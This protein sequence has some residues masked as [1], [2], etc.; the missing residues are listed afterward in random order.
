MKWPFATRV[1]TVL[2]FVLLASLLIQAGTAVLLDLS[3]DALEG[4]LLAPLYSALDLWTADSQV[5][6]SGFERRSEGLEVRQ[7]FLLRDTVLAGAAEVWRAIPPAAK[8]RL[9]AGETVHVRR[10]RDGLFSVAL[11]RVHGRGEQARAFSLSRALPAY[12]R[13]LALARWN[14]L[15]R[16]LG[17]LLLLGAV[18]LVTREL[19]RPFR[20]LQTVAFDAREELRMKSL[21]PQEEWEAVIGT[22]EATI[23]QLR[24]SQRRLHERYVDSES[25]RQRLDRLN[26]QL[27]DALPSALV[28]AD[29][30]GRIVQFNRSAERLPALPAPEQGMHLAE[31][32]APWPELASRFREASPPEVDPAGE[33]MV[34]VNGEKHAFEFSVY[35]VPGGGHL[36]FLQDCT[37]VRRLEALVSQRARMAALGETAAGLAHE[38]RNAMGAIVGYARLLLRPGRTMVDE[39]APR[40]EEEASEMETML[41][42]FL[43]VARPA[44]LQRVTVDGTELLREAAERFRT[45]F[46]AA[47][48]TLELEAG[49]PLRLELDPMWFKQAIVNLL[50]NALQHVPAGG[51][52]LISCEAG[53]DRWQVKVADDGPGIAPEWRSRVLAPFVSLRP[54][55]TGLGLALVQKVMTAHDGQVEISVSEWGGAQ[56]ILTFASNVR[57][58]APDQAVQNSP[59]APGA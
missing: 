12:G 37:Q 39:V 50:E 20:K 38:L 44:E 13:F 59:S 17:L 23:E 33:C 57:A 19:T 9:L 36:V 29:P 47:G 4:D 41:T 16:S 2:L 18:F 1:R 58:K 26:T 3:A 6:S 53:R 31:F 48:V 28:A 25:E 32:F 43:E 46:D 56:V 8:G 30:Q 10:E 55:G 54:G 14:A 40:I 27:I 45:R 24:E 51:R 11:W 52:V 21:P 22:F 5:S 15:F 49:P 42:R 35:P 7:Q 34:T